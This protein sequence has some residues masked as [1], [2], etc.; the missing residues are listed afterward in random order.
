MLTFLI[1]APRPRGPSS[2]V[3]YAP[4]F[5]TPAPAKLINSNPRHRV[6]ISARRVNGISVRRVLLGLNV[7]PYTNTRFKPRVLVLV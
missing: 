2:E 4:A 3:G 7:I 5:F 1:C 6:Q